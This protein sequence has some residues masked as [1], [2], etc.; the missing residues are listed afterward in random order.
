[1]EDNRRRVIKTGGES[2]QLLKPRE[3][4]GGWHNYGKRKSLKAVSDID[5]SGRFELEMPLE[6]K[7][8]IENYRK[9]RQERRREK[10]SRKNIA[11]KVI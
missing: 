5:E 4:N 1:M 9:Q 8:E 10:Y 2:Y 6:T 7:C 11:S 3:E